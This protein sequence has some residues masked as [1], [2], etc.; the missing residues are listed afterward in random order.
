MAAAL[1]TLKLDP[2][3]FKLIQTALEIARL[4]SKIVADN[5]TDP[6]AKA[7]SR[8]EQTRFAELLDKLS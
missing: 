5:A 8:G 2:A 4:E 7:Q 6:R 1:I 3:E